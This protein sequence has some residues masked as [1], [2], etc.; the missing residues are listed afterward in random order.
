MT[1]AKPPRPLP[2]LDAV[3]H[4]GRAVDAEGSP[5]K[6]AGPAGAG[7]GPA[8]GPQHYPMNFT[9]TT[10]E[11]VRALAAG[12]PAWS[13][14]LRRI[15]QLEEE[16]VTALVAIAFRAGALPVELPPA[17]AHKLVTLNGLVASH[18]AYYPIEANLPSNPITRQIMDRGQPW[19]RMEPRTAAALLAAAHDRFTSP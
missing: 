12:P 19:Q 7:S 3:D 18:N 11:R 16:I 8:S 15:E 1:Q 4:A 2:L 5:P 14:R 17:L 6:P 9:L 13:V 10:A